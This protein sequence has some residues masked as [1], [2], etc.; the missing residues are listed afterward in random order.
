MLK[1]IPFQANDTPS[2]LAGTC[3]IITNVSRMSWG[4]DFMETLYRKYRPKKFSELVGQDHVKRVLMRALEENRVSHAYI[5]AGPRGTGKTTTARILAKALNCDNRKDA[6]PCGKCYSCKAIDEGTFMDVV[7]LDA[8]SNRGIDE[9]RRIRDAAS[10]RPIEGKYKV[11][12]IDEVHM[13]TKEAF[14]ALLKTLEEP[15]EHVVFILATTNLEKVPPTIVSR[16]QVLEFRNLPDK[17][18]KERLKQICEKEGIKAS[19]EALSFI[20]RRA[21]GGMRDALTM[22]EQVWKFSE[23]KEI[24]VEDVENALGL[25][26]SEIVKSYVDA[27]VEGDVKKVIQVI[28]EVHYSGKELDVLIQETLDHVLR[29]INSGEVSLIP[30]SKELLSLLREVRM[31]EN[32]KLYLQVASI[33][34]MKKVKEIEPP[35]IVKGEEKN[36]KDAGKIPET[37]KAEIEEQ[38]KETVE[39]EEE[40]NQQLQET[41]VT[42]EEHP[43]VKRVKELLR[44]Q[45]D[46]SLYVALSMAD[47]INVCEKQVKITFAKEKSYHSEII[48]QHLYELE[49][50]FKKA[51]GKNYTIDVVTAET[52]KRQEEIKGRIMSLFGGSEEG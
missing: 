10:F 33:S 5:F 41:A 51:T 14:N 26:R 39:K 36:K 43:D 7:E 44:E 17:L 6:E 40:E 29:R 19:D 11:Y 50:F 15:P 2:L 27:I 32:K 45:G 23:K 34:L 4:S 20:A 31:F 30:L 42:S 25:I 46:L 37:G 52:T 1:K 12:I 28:D 48:K 21:L 38:E 35:E 8:A 9:I 13:L 24:D 3:A 16:C 18:V 49:S 22:L 47:E